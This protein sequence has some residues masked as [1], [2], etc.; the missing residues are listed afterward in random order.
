[1]ERIKALLRQFPGFYSAAQRAFYWCAQFAETRLF[2][3]RFQE[4]RWKRKPVA[5]DSVVF[6]P[7]YVPHPHRTF[8]LQRFD[9]YSPFQ[10][11]LEVGCG[12]GDNLYLL[13][14]QYPHLA[15]YGID[16]NAKAIQNAC[17][18]SRNMH[19]SCRFETGSIYD[20]S[21]FSDRSIDIIFSDAALLYVGPDKIEKALREMARV[22]KKAVIL[23]EWH[24]ESLSGSNPSLYRD[25]HWVHNYA[26]RFYRIA[27]VGKVR[28]TSIPQHIWGGAGWKEYGAVIEACIAR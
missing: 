1:M 16:V 6:G 15:L 24:S 5:G 17:Q 19:I 3:T 13:W 28:A 25:A 4:W 9:S 14:K 22:A 26:A 20:L 23:N 7:S 21:R 18:W 10:S 11:V 2:G 12:R 27:G 8:L